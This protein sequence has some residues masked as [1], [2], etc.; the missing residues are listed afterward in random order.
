MSSSASVSPRRR[1]G[2]VQLIDLDCC[3]VNGRDVG[4]AMVGGGYAEWWRGR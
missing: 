1:V 4:E 2:V 3:M